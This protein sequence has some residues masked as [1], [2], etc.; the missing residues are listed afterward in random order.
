MPDTM[1]CF[2]LTVRLPLDKFNKEKF[3]ICLLDVMMPNKDGF[4]VAKK[5]R[6]QTRPGSHFT[7][8]REIARRRHDTR[9]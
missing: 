9:I 2:A 7:D 3:D 1:W 4:A 5:I 8:H 6:Q